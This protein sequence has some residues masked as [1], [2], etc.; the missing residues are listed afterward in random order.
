MAAISVTASEVV[1]GSSATVTSGTAGTTITAGQSVYKDTTSGNKWKLAASD[2]TTLEAGSGGI[3]VAVNGASDNQPIDVV[4]AGQVNFGASSTN[5]SSG[6]SLCVGDVPGG[7]VPDADVTSGMYKTHLGVCTATD[8][9]TI[10][11]T[12]SGAQV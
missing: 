9:C 1:A 5:V 3:G 11:A 6:V 8:L 4:T 12:A 2:L 7:I 10:A